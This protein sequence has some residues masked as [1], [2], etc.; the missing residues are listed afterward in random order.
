MN[1][2]AGTI[3]TNIGS[4]IL[5]KVRGF[6]RD[7]AIVYAVIA[8]IVVLAFASPE[9]LQVSNFVNVLRQI[10]MIAI[11]AVG[12]FFVMVGA[13]IDISIGAIVGLTGVLFAMFMVNFGMPPIVAFILTIAMGLGIGVVNGFMVAKLGIPAM[14]ATLAAQSVCRGMVYVITGA[15]PISG[16]PDSISFLGRG[17]VGGLNWLPW[18]VFILLIVAV[19]AHIVSERT[20]FGR[21]VYA[22]GGN[23]EA[24]HLSG[25][26][27]KKIEIITY[28]ICGGLAALSGTILTSRMA[29]GQPN[30]GLTWEF[31][32]IIAAVIGGV[33]ITGGRGK[34]FG[35]LFGAILVG[36]LTNGMTLLN[37]NSY[38]QQVVKGVVMVVAIAFD[39]YSV[40]K[41]Q[42]K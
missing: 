14:I 7:Y 1:K 21:S 36:L 37:V 3:Q 18:P 32:A 2:T 19:I 35:A 6:F 11:L 16:L 34:V 25:I 10:S 33:S 30:G 23:P 5:G 31:E 15:Y 24:A 9:F 12:V 20:K 42:K 27:H 29:S 4:R 26:K 17:Y 38:Y 40:K 8:L 13:G 28:I 39:V 41:K 22:I